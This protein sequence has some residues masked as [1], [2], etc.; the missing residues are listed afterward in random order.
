[1]MPQWGCRTRQA[2]PCKQLWKLWSRLS[3]SSSYSHSKPYNFVI[4]QPIFVIQ[5]SIRSWSI[6]L[7]LLPN[8]VKKIWSEKKIKKENIDFLAKKNFFFIFS[9]FRKLVLIFETNLGNFCYHSN[10]LCY[11]AKKMKIGQKLLELNHFE[12]YPKNSKKSQK[13]PKYKK[14]WN[15]HKSKKL[16]KFIFTYPYQV[17]KT[18]NHKWK[19]FKGTHWVP[20]RG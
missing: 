17:S 14:F 18:S 3:P 5:L 9:Y 8:F 20:L 12:N 1:M 6:R 4:F 13:L 19:S 10:L 2:K 16:L 11:E 15:N 7:Q